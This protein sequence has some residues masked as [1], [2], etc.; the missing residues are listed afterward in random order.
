MLLCIWYGFPIQWTKEAGEQSESGKRTRVPP[1]EQVCC[2]NCTIHRALYNLQ[3]ILLKYVIHYSYFVFKMGV[4]F[5][6]LKLPQLLIAYL[7]KIILL[8]EILQLL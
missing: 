6:L 7:E 3:N 8:C 2:F 1:N 4:N 5:F